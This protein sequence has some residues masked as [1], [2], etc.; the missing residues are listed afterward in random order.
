MLLCVPIS[1]PMLLTSQVISMSQSLQQDAQ[2]LDFI[3]NRFMLLPDLDT[4]YS[5]LTHEW[6]GSNLSISQVDLIDNFY[7]FT[8]LIPSPCPNK[9]KV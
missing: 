6:S 2:E 9:Y 5:K 8:Q 4:L 7:L 1:D 3:E